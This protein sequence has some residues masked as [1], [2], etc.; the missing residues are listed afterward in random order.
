M[1][2]EVACTRAAAAPAYDPTPGVDAELSAA[3]LAAA[4][5]MSC[6]L[7]PRTESSE[8]GVPAP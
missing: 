5:A 2:P 6:E 1:R 7:W 8:V 3:C 4:W